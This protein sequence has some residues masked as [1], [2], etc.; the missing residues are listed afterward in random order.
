MLPVLEDIALHYFGDLDNLISFPEVKLPGV[1]KL[2]YVLIRHKPMKVEIDD[3]VPIEFQ[4]GLSHEIKQSILG[5]GIIYKGWNVKGYWVLLEDVYSSLAKQ[6]SFM[7]SDYSPAHTCRFAL[8]EH[9]PQGN[10]ATLTPSR[11]VSIDIDE[12]YDLHSITDLP[13]KNDF[14]Q[15]L[16]TRLQAELL[17]DLVK[18]AR[19][20][21]DHQN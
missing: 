7:G 17:G 10:L 18:L 14:V 20:I 5:K 16:S 21:N 6:Y 8:Y 2:D 12:V 1:G 13:S 15:N 4:T 11:Y 19:T 9:F 3:F